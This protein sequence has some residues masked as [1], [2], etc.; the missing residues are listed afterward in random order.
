MK[1]SILIPTYNRCNDLRKNLELLCKFIKND[2]LESDVCICVSDNAS[3]DDTESLMH[4]FLSKEVCVKYY[5]NDAN[6]GYCKNVLSLLSKAETE[7]VMLLG[8]DDYLESWYLKGCLEQ[9]KLY[10]NLGCI[11]ANYVDYNASTG[12][13]GSLRE[14]NCPTQYYKAGF[15]ACIENMWR[16][17]QVSGLCFRR[18]KLVE[19]YLNQHMNN[20]YPQMFFVG[21]NALRYDVLHFGEKCLVVSS[22]SQ[23]KKDWNYGN[24]GLMNDICENFKNLNISYKQRAKLEADFNARQQRYLWASNDVNQCIDNILCAKNISLLGKYYISKQILQQY[25]YS[26]KRHKVW[27]YIISSI[28]SMKYLLRGKQGGN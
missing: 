19:V 14:E 3:T 1:L 28:I 25:P 23:E 24:D 17:H 21:F 8:D 12:Q 18:N 11:I 27:F 5:R 22:V 26:G 7:W 15:N 9:I 13:Y 10:S 6:V 4:L 16:A 20:L 2:K